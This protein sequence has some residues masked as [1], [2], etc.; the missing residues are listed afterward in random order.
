MGLRFRKSLKIFKGLKLNFSGSGVSLTVGGRGGSVTYGKRGAFVNLGIPGTGISFRKKVSGGS[1]VKRKSRSGGLR[2]YNSSSY[3]GSRSSTT[4]YPQ[5][6]Y[7]GEKIPDVDLRMVRAL[8]NEVVTLPAVSLEFVQRRCQVQ[9]AK[10]VEIMVILEEMGVISHA[11]AD[12]LAEVRVK[13]AGELAEAWHDYFSPCASSSRP[14]VTVTPPSPDVNSLSGAPG[15]L[16]DSKGCQFASC[17][18]VAIMA[19]LLLAYVFYLIS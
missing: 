12:G 6:A 10:A 16:L 13:T 9:H 3:R 1:S 19:I 7:S 18:V 8:A 11:G 2:D 17:L 4:A 5:P 15:C 14:G